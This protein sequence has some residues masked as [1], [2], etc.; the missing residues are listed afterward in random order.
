MVS[1]GEISSILS[2]SGVSAV[3]GVWV[4]EL[5]PQYC[6]FSSPL[7]SPSPWFCSSTGTIRCH[8]SSTFCKFSTTEHHSRVS[9]A[10]R[11]HLCNCCVSPAVHVGWQLPAVEMEYPDGL[12]RYK[13]F[14]R[15]L[16]EGQVLQQ[17]PNVP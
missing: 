17:N 4:P 5:L 11:L 1:P 6:H 16:L 7:E 15:F 14:S 12:E 13:L 8:R 10:T 9:K 2:R 3:E